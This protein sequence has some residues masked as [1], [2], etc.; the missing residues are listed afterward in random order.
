MFSPPYINPY[1][2][3]GLFHPCQLDKSISKFRAVWCTFSIFILNRI[4]L[5]ANS[6]DPDQTPHSVAFDQGL[7]CLPRS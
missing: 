5:Q 3:S 6:V 4:S 2:P 1:L 7:H